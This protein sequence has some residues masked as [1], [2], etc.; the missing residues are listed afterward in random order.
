V[1]LLLR[2]EYVDKFFGFVFD[3]DGC[4]VVSVYFSGVIG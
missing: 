1:E 2:L 4:V 3:G